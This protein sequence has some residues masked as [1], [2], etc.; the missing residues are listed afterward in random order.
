LLLPL[1]GPST[2]AGKQIL[3]GFMLATKERDTH[4]DTE[5]DGHLGGLDVYISRIDSTGTPEAAARKAGALFRREKIEFLTIFASRE[6][7]NALYPAVADAKVFLLGLGDAPR[8]ILGN[9]CPPY[10][11]S[12]SSRKGAEIGR[13]FAASF[14]KE[15]GRAP[16][17]LAALGYDAA[18]LIGSAV[19][20]LG[21]ELAGRAAL[22]RALRDST[23][24]PAHATIVFAGN[25]AC[26]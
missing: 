6:A 26:R 14:Q 3:D 18:R 25:S 5:S 11:I 21:G 24:R 12:I 8:K 2:G 13:A 20:A 19:R 4:P 7:L 9:A 1:S 16:S 17:R 10:F 15:F 22:R 23:Y